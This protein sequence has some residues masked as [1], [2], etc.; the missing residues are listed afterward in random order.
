MNSVF[1]NASKSNLGTIDRVKMW[2]Y[3]HHILNSVIVRYPS[4]K[5]CHY[6]VNGEDRTQDIS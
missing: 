3:W 6:R 4:F 5:C 2:L 1:K